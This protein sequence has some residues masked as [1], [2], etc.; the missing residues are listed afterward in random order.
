MNSLLPILLNLTQNIS[1]F[2]MFVLGYAVVRRRV[3]ARGA[4]ASGIFVGTLFGFAAILVMAS[5]FQVASGVIVDTRNVIIAVA[6]VVGGPL[7]GC[8]TTLM[9]AAYRLHLGGVGMVPALAGMSIAFAIA[10]AFRRLCGSDPRKPARLALLGLAVAVGTLSSFLLLPADQ[11]LP[12]MQRTAAPLILASTVGSYL[13][14]VMLDRERRWSEVQEQLRAREQQLST[15]IDSMS[16]GLVVANRKGDITLSNPAAQRLSGVTP[17]D[18]PSGEWTDLFGVFA[19]DGRTPF[20]P[21]HLPLARALKGDACDEVELIMR[22]AANPTGRLLSVSGRPLRDEDGAPDGGVVVFRDI[23]QQKHM[24]EELRAAKQRFE[25]AIAGSQDGIFDL[26]LISGQCWTSARFREIRGRPDAPEVC[27]VEFWASAIVPDDRELMQRQM[28]AL[29]ASNGNQMDA[30]YR[31][32]R[33][34][35]RI[36]HIRTRAVTIRDEAGVPIRLVGSTADITPLKEA[37][38]R[39]R[40]AI[41]NM[42][43]GFALFDA[44]DRLVVYNKGFV[45]EGTARNFGDPAGRTFEEIMRAF[46]HDHGFTAT[47]ALHDRAGWLAWRLEQ[48]RNPPPDP[49]EIEW[50]DGRWMRVTERRT[51]EGGYVGLWTDITEQKRRQVDLEYSKDQLTI[52]AAEL[53]ELAEGLEEARRDAERAN[54]EKSR[55]LASMSHEL[56]TPLNAILGFSDMMR[57]ETFGPIVPERYGEYARMI[58]DSGSH[59]LS[60]INDVLDLSKI[61]AGKME[62]M[63]EPLAPEEVARQAIGLTA[64][65]AERRGIAVCRDIANDCEIIHGDARAVKQMLLNLMSNAIKFTE[66]GGTIRLAFSKSAERVSIS[67][68]DTGIGMTEAEMAKAL[69]PYGQVDSAVARKSVG[70]GLGLPLVKALA[71]LHGG[72]LTLA[73]EKGVGTTVSVVLPLRAELQAA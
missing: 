63:V 44:N 49:L 31:V 43:S 52:Q 12:V 64:E 66:P 51:S 16:D 2:V 45:D 46:A 10:L 19:P 73:S 29:K 71:E 72:S 35:G 18:R 39:L 14:G 17:T 58:H 26:N 6:T 65:L 41:D 56:R 15:I 60:L 69:E 54:Q 23:T 28:E 1:L 57:L 9:A 48:H 24:E 42:E 8:V 55:F 47:A 61:E 4:F 38:I 62:L 67:V 34:S 32:V 59:L 30:I 68:A 27:P 37:E 50:T 22:N 70:T 36:I 3:A 25:L 5:P 20:P 53:A 11:V 13:L 21:E 7:S 40:S 33:P